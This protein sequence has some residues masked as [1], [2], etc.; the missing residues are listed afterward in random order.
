M[1]NNLDSRS[2]DDFDFLE[3][4]PGLASPPHFVFQEKYF[5]C[6]IVLT[7]KSHCLVDFSFWDLGNMCTRLY[8]GSN[9]MHQGENY[10]DFL[11]W[12]G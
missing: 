12:V 10:Q 8:G 2:K 9:E 1:C 11:N 5:S 6:Y 7:G 4:G 3:K